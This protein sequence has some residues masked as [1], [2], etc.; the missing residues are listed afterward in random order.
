MRFAFFTLLL[1]FLAVSVLAVAPLQKAVIVS[2]DDNTPDHVI[3]EAKSA[4][5][6][7]VRRIRSYWDGQHTKLDN[8][9]GGVITHEYSKSRLPLL[10]LTLAD[11]CTELIKY[12]TAHTIYSLRTLIIQQSLC[13]QGLGKSPRDCFSVGHRVQRGS[14]GRRN[15][16]NQWWPLNKT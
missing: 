9:Q 11:Q 3:A 16:F 4:I 6:A 14:R 15:G 13:G 8:L 1:A 2:Y 12:E 10:C 5:K 7:A